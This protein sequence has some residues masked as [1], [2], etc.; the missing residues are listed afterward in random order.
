[1]GQLPGFV[2]VGELREVWSLGVRANRLCGCGRPFRSCPFWNAVGEQAFGGW[3]NLDVE[4]MVALAR[5]V[6]RHSRWPFLVWPG[7]APHLRPLLTEYTDALSRL[8]LAIHDVAQSRV[9]IDSSK[10]PSTAFV[11]RNVQGL[12]LRIA[13]LIRDP[14]GVAYSWTKT[15]LRPDTARRVYMQR[16]H[17]VRTALRWNTRN[18]LMEILGRLG[19]PEVRIRYEQVVASPRAVVGRVADALDESITEEQLDFIREREVLLAPN[20]TVMG[21]PMR[22]RHGPTSL[23]LDTEWRRAMHPAVRGAVTLVTWPMARRYGYDR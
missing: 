12:D 17:P 7:I 2:S 23:R 13:H 22:M 16:Y 3:D 5:R 21:N 19:V 9:V 14:H 20:H 6:D 15:V 10:A 1:M 4:R 8:Y 11:L 18:A